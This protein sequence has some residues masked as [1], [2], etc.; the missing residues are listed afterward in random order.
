MRWPECFMNAGHLKFC[1]IIQKSVQADAGVYIG[2]K[3]S[4]K[5]HRPE[6]RWAKTMSSKNKVVFTARQEAINQGYVPG[7]GKVCKP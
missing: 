1:L 6:C 2:N 7:K 5:F 3:R 4:H